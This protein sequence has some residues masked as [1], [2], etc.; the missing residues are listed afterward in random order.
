MH[1]VETL[2]SLVRTCL[3]TQAAT[4]LAL[5]VAGSRAVLVGETPDWWFGTERVA[6]AFEAQLVGA[7][8]P[9]R[10]AWR[11]LTV[12]DGARA[13]ARHDGAGELDDLSNPLARAPEA[14]ANACQRFTSC[15]ATHNLG[16]SLP[17]ALKPSAK[18]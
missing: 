17:E 10:R 11:N 13:L 18:Q 8:I 5:P 2:P 1:A 16:V 3:S 12:R 9:P 14:G 15:V 6:V 4:A 7:A